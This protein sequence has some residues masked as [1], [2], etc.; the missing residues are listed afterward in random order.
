MATPAPPALAEATFAALGTTVHVVTGG[1]LDAAVA[2]V[3]AELD[4]IDR[5]CSRFRADS[6]LSR[7][8]DA[9]GTFVGVG[10]TFLRAL[11]VALDAAAATDGA[12]DPTVGEALRVLGYDRDFAAMDRCGPPLLRV[13]PVPG[14]QVVDVDPARGR[15]R[16]PAG[17]RLD[18]GATAKGLAADRAAVRASRAAAAGCLVGVGGDIAVAGDAPPEGWLVGVADS[19]RT[20]FEDADEAVLL[21]SGGVATSSVTVRCWQRGGE[22][23]HHLVDPATGTSTT[24]PWRTVTVAAP[25]CVEANIGSTAGIVLGE[26]GAPWL[27]RRGHPARLVAVNGAVLRLNGWPEEER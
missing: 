6:D 26:R 13:G 23:R 16:V 27:V 18:L 8:N 4:E 9:A 25:S 7:V 20:P 5:A 19:H 24:G 12:V 14:W 1:D 11:R 21:W 3:R 17:V 10:A 2:G 15:V 22:V